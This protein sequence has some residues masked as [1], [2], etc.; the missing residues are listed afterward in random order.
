MT[1]TKTSGS[2]ETRGSTVA[3]VGIGIAAEVEVGM[4]MGAPERR[5]R[6]SDGTGAGVATEVDVAAKMI[7]A[8]IVIRGGVSDHDHALGRMGDGGGD[9]DL[10]LSQGIE[11]AF[12]ADRVIQA[13]GIIIGAGKKT[14]IDVVPKRLQRPWKRRSNQFH[15]REAGTVGHRPR[16]KMNWKPF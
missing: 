11:D 16:Q 9:R 14:V 3:H 7:I 10:V 8:T 12:A 4:E 15:L 1:T 2:E 5:I 13:S 6:E